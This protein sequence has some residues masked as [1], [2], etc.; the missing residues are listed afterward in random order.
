MRYTHTLITERVVQEV[1]LRQDKSDV[2]TIRPLLSSGKI[3]SKPTPNVPIISD[4][5]AISETDCG[6]IRLG[7][8]MPDLITIIDDKEE[9]LI[10]CR[11]GLRPMFLLDVFVLLTTSYDLDKAM[12]RNMIQSTAK[13]YSPAYV[14][15]TL[16]MLG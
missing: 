5:Y 7:L 4:Y 6:V 12:A 11:Y 2:R 13:R 10:A 15:H 8:A 14:A 9:F 3:I 16:S 1:V